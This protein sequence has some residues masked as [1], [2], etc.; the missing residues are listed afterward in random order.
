ML[1]R[2]WRGLRTLAK[3]APVLRRQ[4]LFCVLVSD[5]VWIISIYF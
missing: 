4:I 2:Q 1:E 3:L 5:I